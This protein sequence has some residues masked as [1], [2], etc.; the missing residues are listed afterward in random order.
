[1]LTRGW[2]PAW[3]G[4]DATEMHKKSRLLP[5]KSSPLDS[6]M[7]SLWF[8]LR[9]AVLRLA[10]SSLWTVAL[11]KSRMVARRGGAPPKCVN[12]H[13]LERSSRSSHGT[14]SS[15]APSVYLL[16]RCGVDSAG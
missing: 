10:V 1:M 11:D 13:P 4:S 12:G 6:S 7:I 14:S 8:A 15:P 9:A 3:G 5:G 2:L 16:H